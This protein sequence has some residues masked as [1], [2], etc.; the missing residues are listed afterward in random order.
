MRVFK[1]KGELFS[2]LQNFHSIGFVPTMGALHEGHLELVKTALAEN[3]C[4]VVSIFI[5]PLQFNN[6]GDLQN[7]PRMPEEDLILLQK[8]GCH[9]LFMPD[10]NEMYGDDEQLL[11]LDLG[12]LDM[13]MEG[14]FRPGHF[15]GVI[16]VVDKFFSIIKP[17]NAYFGE[18]DFQQLAIIR[19]MANRL[20]PSI[21]IVGCPTVRQKDGLAMSSRNQR[22]TAGEK[23]EAAIIFRNLQY[24]KSQK[25]KISIESVKNDVVKNINRISSFKVEYFEIVN[26]ETLMSV[27]D[28]DASVPL[29]ACIAVNTSTVRLIDNIEL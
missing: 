9:V 3:A 17:S 22:L 21:N 13:V 12:K 6:A 14:A 29:R 23:N 26:A 7:Y 8:T 18:K 27:E 5:N 24:A 20:H 25:H 1:A 11:N 16:T 28:W 15:K 10:V 19:F 4:V 2:H